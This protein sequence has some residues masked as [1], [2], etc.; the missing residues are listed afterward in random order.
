MKTWL[1]DADIVIDLL[2]LNVFDNLVRDHEIY[3]SSSVADEIIYFK[4]DGVRHSINFRI[5]YVQKK[6]LVELS[7]S[8]GDITQLTNMLPRE[9]MPTIHQGELESL[10]LMLKRSELILCSCDAAT[11]RVL[12]ILDLSERGI[13]AEKLLRESGLPTQGLQDRH[14]EKYFK[15]NLAIGQANKIYSFGK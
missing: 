12:P 8:I 6:S 14:T 5:D 13:S 7:A 1:L 4:R 11:I 2:A 9:I 10:A 3:V 15:N